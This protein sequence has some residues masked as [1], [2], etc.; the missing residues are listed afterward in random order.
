MARKQRMKPLADS[1]IP[2]LVALGRQVVQ[3]GAPLEPGAEEARK[4]WSETAGVPL[5]QPGG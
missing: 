5:R 1:E 3:R 2:T 4:R